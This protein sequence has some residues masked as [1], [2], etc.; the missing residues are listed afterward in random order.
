[1]EEDKREKFKRPSGDDAAGHTGFPNKDARF[2][3]EDKIIENNS[4]KYFS[5]RASFIGNPVGCEFES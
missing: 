5:N 1:M 2:Y 4:F 3:K